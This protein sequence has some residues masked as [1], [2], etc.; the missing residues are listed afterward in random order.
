MLSNA[1]GNIGY[2]AMREP[3]PDPAESKTLC[4]RGNSLHGN[5]EIPPAPTADGAMGRS[6]KANSRTSDMHADGR[7]DGPIV[8]E[9][10]PNN[11]EPV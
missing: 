7:S 1:E 5:R 10:P 9:K 3:S 2:D 4:M 8:P 6:E 11:D